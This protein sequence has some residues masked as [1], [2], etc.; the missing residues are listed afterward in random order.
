MW[1]LQIAGPN[2]Q[3]TGVNVFA[4]DG[5]LKGSTVPLEPPPNISARPKK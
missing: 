1:G 3:S 2:H 4:E 5:V